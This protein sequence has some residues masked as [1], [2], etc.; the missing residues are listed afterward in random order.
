MQTVLQAGAEL[1]EGEDEDLGAVMHIL[2]PRCGVA[3]RAENARLFLEDRSWLRS[4]LGDRAVWSFYVKHHRLFMLLFGSRSP[5]Q[6]LPGNTVP[7]LQSIIE[8][9]PKVML[10]RMAQLARQKK[11]KEC[12]LTKAIQ[13][14]SSSADGG[15]R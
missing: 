4:R 9:R 2:A 12:T 5:L 3:V 10:W 7:L 6:Y 11:L 13:A 8:D 14:L 15:M 1:E